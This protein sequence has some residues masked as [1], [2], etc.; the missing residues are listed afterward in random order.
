MGAEG[1][2]PDLLRGI[3]MMWVGFVVR[4]GRL[5]REESEYRFLEAWRRWQIA[6][7]IRGGG[8]GRVERTLG[9]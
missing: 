8:I 9:R 1:R 6:G 7:P 4:V 3:A 5:L 2:P